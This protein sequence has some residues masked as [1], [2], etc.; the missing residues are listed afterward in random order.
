MIL[1]DAGAEIIKAVET[2]AITATGSPEGHIGMQED[3]PAA[4]LKGGLTGG[5]KGD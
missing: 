2:A 3:P 4:V 1:Q 5:E